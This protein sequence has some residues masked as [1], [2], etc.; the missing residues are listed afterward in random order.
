MTDLDDEF[1][2]F[3]QLP[4]RLRRA[5]NECPIKYDAQSVWLQ[6]QAGYTQRQII[7]QFKQDVLSEMHLHWSFT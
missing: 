6:L 3:D 4:P 2:Y 1:D 5:I 7:D